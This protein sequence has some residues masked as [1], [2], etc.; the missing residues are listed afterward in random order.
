MT[1]TFRN[2][3]GEGTASV[4]FRLWDNPQFSGF[5]LAKC[6]VP[7]PDAPTNGTVSAGCTA[8]SGDLAAY[9]RTHPRGSVWFSVAVDNP[10]GNS[11]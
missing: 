2:Y 7:V 5:A 9:F 1:A 4:T 11:P 8:T 6:T 10:T 3:G